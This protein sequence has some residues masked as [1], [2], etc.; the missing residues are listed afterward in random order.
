MVA[1]REWERWENVMGCYMPTA[2][3]IED[4]K[5]EL[6]SR[7]LAAKLDSDPNTPDR[8]PRV[9]RLHENGRVMRKAVH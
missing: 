2:E 8:E 6:K 5:A 3:E 9:V 7:H 1:S 4:A